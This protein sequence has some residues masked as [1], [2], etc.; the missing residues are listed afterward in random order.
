MTISIQGHCGC[1]VTK[2]TLHDLD[3]SVGLDGERRRGAAQA[4]RRQALDADGG[5]SLIER[6]P[7]HTEREMST[8]PGGEHQRVGLEGQVCLEAIP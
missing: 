3:V 6:L 4:V 5:A 7:I 2:Q 8:L 1:G